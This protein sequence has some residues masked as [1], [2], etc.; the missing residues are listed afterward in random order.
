MQ[1]SHLGITQT[2]AWEKKGKVIV[3]KRS[4]KDF[5]RT[6]IIAGLCN[7][8]CVAPMSFPGTCNA[9]VFNT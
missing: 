8:K 4:G 1:R 7:K 9:E 6:N 3:G 2:R 5:L